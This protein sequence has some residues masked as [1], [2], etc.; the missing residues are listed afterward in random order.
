[1]VKTSKSMKRHTLKNKKTSL[2]HCSFVFSVLRSQWPD[3]H[4]FIYF[5]RDYE[6]KHMHK[7]NTSFSSFVI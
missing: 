6:N 3:Y 7:A 5:S 1:M 2:P 4:C